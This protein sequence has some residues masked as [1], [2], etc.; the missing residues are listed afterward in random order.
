M[1][2]NSPLHRLSAL[3]QSV[4]IDNLSRDS[5]RKGGLQA[6]IDD[7]AVVGA[8][9]N[10]SIFE[11]AMTAGD[12]AYDDQLRTLKGTGEPGSEQAEQV[13]W[14]LAQQDVGEACDLFRSTWDGGLGRD[15]YVSIE[16]DPRLAYDTLATFRE[17]I[18]LHETIDRPNLLVKIPATKPGL[19]AIEDVIAKG[20]SINVTLIFSL[21]R[22]EEVAESYVRGL[23]RL[24]AEGGDPRVVSSVASFFVSRIDT[25]ADSR[26]DELAR[27]DAASAPAVAELKGKLAVANA[28]LAYQRYRHVFA[29][30]RWEYL[31]GKGATPQRVLWASTSTKSPDYPDT[32][33]VDELIGPDTVNTMPEETIRAFQDHGSPRTRLTE[34]V[35]D[36]QSVFERLAAVGVD[37][38]DVTDT[39]E[40]E[41]VEK[42]EASFGELISSLEEKLG[43]LAA[44]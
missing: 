17:A 6:L 41:G 14:A 19:A 39:L 44:A 5:I 9:S 13:F 25:E 42:F 37:Y 23:E 40:R 11:K 31:A 38:D 35:A 22:Y 18:R 36:A 1:S 28:K 34:G 16:V 32:L 12:G 15:G 26:L 43:A 24:V 27:T 3:G 20:K 8:T 29:G 33:Y 2:A 10:P 4:W 21:R 30:P 7:D